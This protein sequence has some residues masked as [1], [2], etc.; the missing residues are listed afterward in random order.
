MGDITLGTISSLFKDFG[1][2]LSMLILVLVTGVRA[3]WVFGWVY[4]E[5]KDDRDFWRKQAQEAK[6]VARVGAQTI[7]EVVRHVSSGSEEQ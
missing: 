3:D 1:L 6:E 5:L 7:K 4:R 2:P